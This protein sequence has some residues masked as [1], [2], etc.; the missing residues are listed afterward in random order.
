MA[1][2]EPVDL[3]RLRAALAAGRFEW[4][5]HALERM[6]ERGISQVAALHV[7]QWGERI[8]DYAEDRPY[9]SALLLGWHEGKPVHAVAAFD[10]QH[11]WAYVITV[12]EP[13]LEHFEA[14]YRTRRSP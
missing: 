2:G 1:A 8:E 7:L 11:D 10:P 14:D 12:Y 5:R 9:A 4:R 13:D 3:A 6:A